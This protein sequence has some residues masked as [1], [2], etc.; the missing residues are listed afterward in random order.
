MQDE[1]VIDT[2]QDNLTG[3]TAPIGQKFKYSDIGGNVT[4]N[5]NYSR[6][7]CVIE[8]QSTKCKQPVS[9]LFDM[10][11]EGRKSIVSKRRR[12]RTPRGL[13]LLIVF[14]TSLPLLTRCRLLVSLRVA[15]R[16]HATPIFASVVGRLTSRVV[17]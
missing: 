16:L 6:E 12:L 1:D 4:L 5:M 13:G 7:A 2:L 15:H 14:S 10:V 9:P 17:V 3:E 8:V 11:P